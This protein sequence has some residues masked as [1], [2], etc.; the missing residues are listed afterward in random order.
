MHYKIGATT[1]DVIFRYQRTGIIHFNVVSAKT[2]TSELELHSFY[3]TLYMFIKPRLQSSLAPFACGRSYHQ[4][5][6]ISAVAG[7]K[8][9]CGNL[10]KSPRTSSFVQ[11]SIPSGLL[12]S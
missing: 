12:E 7:V 11:L 2:A 4:N 1:V 6:F 10:E 3:L 5:L 9:L 8:C